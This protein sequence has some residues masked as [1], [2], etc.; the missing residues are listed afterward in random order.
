MVDRFKSQY[1]H[2]PPTMRKAIGFNTALYMHQASGCYLHYMREFARLAPP[3]T[4]SEAE[5]ELL[6]M[7][8][9]GFLDTDL[10]HS[11]SSRVPPG[12]VNDVSAL[13]PGVSFES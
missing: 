4:V 11:L 12:D 3:E 8:R 9:M 6:P 13:R 2:S 1:D 5:E 7:L 10:H